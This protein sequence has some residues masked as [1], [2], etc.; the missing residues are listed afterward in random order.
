METCLTF[1]GKTQGERKPARRAFPRQNDELK[2]VVKAYPV[3]D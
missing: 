2:T 1:P 3:R